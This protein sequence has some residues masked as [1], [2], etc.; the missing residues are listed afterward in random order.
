MLNFIKKFST[1]PQY[2][3]RVYLFTLVLLLGFLGTL[4]ISVYHLLHAA[5]YYPYV[6]FLYDPV[7][8]HSDFTEMYWLFANGIQVF[9]E[10]VANYLP[11]AF[12]LL[13]PFSF[14]PQQIALYTLEILF[15]ASTLCI[16]YKWLPDIPYKKWLTFVITFL[17][18]PVLFVLNR[19]NIEMLLFLLMALFIG[20]YKKGKFYQAGFFLACAIDFK[21]YPIVFLALFLAD[22]RF[23]AFFA[24]ILF[25]IVIL[26]TGFYITG[27][28]KN[29]LLVG[30]NS[31][32][33]GQF[34]TNLLQFSHSLWNIVRLPVFLLLSNEVSPS[35]WTIFFTFSERI[36][37]YYV[38]WAAVL[39]GIIFLR[40]TFFKTPLWQKVFLLALAQTS[41]P[42]IAP[43]Y[44]LLILFLP[45]LLFFGEKNTI[46]RSALISCVSGLAL[47]PMSFVLY[48]WASP[49]ATG[50]LV[51]NLGCL[52]R[53][54]VLLYLL[55]V[56]LLLP[57]PKDLP[58]TLLQ[59]NGKI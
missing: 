7:Y 1:Q 18:F 56:L 15:T 51:I 8:I 49:N 9:K 35:E 58:Y 31:Y 20:C 29:L 27:G 5:P 3:K 57:A 17:S 42:L 24:T 48:C 25:T 21:I 37:F 39:G 10:G 16:I 2:A 12:I 34:T 19:G 41:F 55:V 38:L 13:Y 14:L 6:S 59:K 44:S 50:Y 23:K 43:D 4:C 32:F 45:I 36:S 28:D 33:G 11:V 40:I 52:A 46:P 53:P 54:F 22:R 26:I 30:F 47:V